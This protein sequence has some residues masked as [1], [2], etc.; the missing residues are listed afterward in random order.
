VICARYFES[1]VVEGVKMLERMA[2]EDEA[3]SVVRRVCTRNVCARNCS[4][5]LYLVP[6]MFLRVQL[7]GYTV[8]SAGA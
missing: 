2:C 1:V 3:A 8:C 7:A 5:P 4:R 6:N